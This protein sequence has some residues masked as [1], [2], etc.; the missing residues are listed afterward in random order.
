MCMFM[1]TKTIT[2]MDDAYD[3]LKKSKMPNESFS[4]VIRRELSG[5]KKITDF[6]GAWSNFDTDALKKNIAEN[7]REDKKRKHVRF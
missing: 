6:Y 1:S 5:K 2:I 3:L 4:D 7:R